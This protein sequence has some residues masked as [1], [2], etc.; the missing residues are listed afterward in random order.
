[1]GLTSTSSDGPNLIKLNPPNA[2]ANW[3]CLPPAKL[4]SFLSIS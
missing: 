3:S 4:R 2:A 1:M